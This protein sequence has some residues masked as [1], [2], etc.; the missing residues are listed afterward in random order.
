MLNR[1]KFALAGAILSLGFA[2]GASQA[3]V[4]P[5]DAVRTVAAQ[6]SGEATPIHYRRH[7]H[8]HHGHR[9]HHRKHWHGRHGHRHCGWVRRCGKWSCRI[10]RRCHRH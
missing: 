6:A 3:A 8:A 10:V 9:W 5:G 2:A 7:R 4:V 1:F